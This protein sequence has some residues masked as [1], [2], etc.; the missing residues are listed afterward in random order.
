MKKQTF[1]AAGL[2]SLALAAPA[3]A[4]D[5][6]ATTT[7]PSTGQKIENTADKVGNKAESAAEKTGDF[8][9]DSAL[10]AKVKTAL[11]AEKDLK[12][13]KINVDSKDGVVTLTGELPNSA[14]VAQAETA[15]KAVKGVK[16]VHNN[17]TVKFG[18][19]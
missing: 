3:F 10:T 4:D 15:T 7:E 6:A 9:S 2:L 16:E 5:A 14:S 18:K 1:L 12:S 13:M 19:S 8:L 11:I 17:L